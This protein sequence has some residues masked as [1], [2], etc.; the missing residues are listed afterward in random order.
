MVNNTF[1][2]RRP[3]GTFV[4]LAEG[5][6]ARL[7]NNLLVGPGDL[8][9]RVGVPATANRRVR[10]SGLRRPATDD[11]RLTGHVPCGRPRSTV[12]ARWRAR[13]EYAHPARLRRRAVVGRIDLGAYELG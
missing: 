9:N 12:P 11:F 4:G 1:V 5:S 10:A 3:S 6:R 7:R 8:T 13:W 2:N